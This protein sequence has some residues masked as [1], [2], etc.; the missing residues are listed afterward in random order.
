MNWAIIDD[1]R[2]IVRAEI[3]TPLISDSKFTPM[4]RAHRVTHALTKSPLQ[5]ADK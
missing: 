1:V 2:M 4:C 5:S 3:P